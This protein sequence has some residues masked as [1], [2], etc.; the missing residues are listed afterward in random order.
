[1]HAQGWEG[2]VHLVNP[3]HTVTAAHDLVAAPA[4]VAAL[5]VSGGGLR[6]TAVGMTS[7]AS[8]AAGGEGEVIVLLSASIIRIVAIAASLS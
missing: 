1:M 7:A 4:P 2:S 3:H 8:A 6:E 5:A